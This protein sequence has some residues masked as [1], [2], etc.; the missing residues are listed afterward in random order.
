MRSVQPSQYYRCAD[1]KSLDEAYEFL[2]PPSEP[3]PT[4]RISST[5]TWIL[6]PVNNCLHRRAQVL[7][8]PERDSRSLS[9]E[10]VWPFA[11]GQQ[12]ELMPLPLGSHHLREWSRQMGRYRNSADQSG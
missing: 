7:R 8:L 2:G 4:L 1:E 6:T 3:R 10:M 12:H 5:L 9:Q 11:P